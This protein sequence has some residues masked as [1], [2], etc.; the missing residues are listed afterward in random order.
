[1]K[2]AIIYYS[3]TGNTKRAADVL[4]EHLKQK[5]QVEIIMLKGLDESGNFLMQSARALRHKRA[6]IQD[7]NFNLSGHDLICFGTPVWAFGPAPSMN[8]YLDSCLGAEGKDIILFTT[9]G[10]GTGNKRCLDYMQNILTKKGA[11]SFKRFSVQQF[12]VGDKEF[13][14]S[15][16]KKVAP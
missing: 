7:V 1:M 15:K 4:A 16:I 5:G 13:V 11:G 6:N 2:S 14:A 12:K 8:T 3:Y 10:S 9:Y